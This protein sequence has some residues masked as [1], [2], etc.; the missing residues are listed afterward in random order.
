MLGGLT[1][2]PAQPASAAG[3][4]PIAAGADPFGAFAF[5]PID[6]EVD[7]PAPAAAKAELP[8]AETEGDEISA[9]PPVERVGNGIFGEFSEASVSTGAMD[10]E[11]GKPAGFEAFGDASIDPGVADDEGFVWFEAAAEEAAVEEGFG[12]F[13][14]AEEAAAVV[15]AEEAAAVVAA[16]EEEAAEEAA[17]EAAVEGEAVKGAVQ[18]AAAGLE[19]AAGGG[20]GDAGGF[21]AFE[22][23]DELEQEAIASSCFGAFETVGEQEVIAVAPASFGA[24]VAGEAAEEEEA[25]AVEEAVAEVAVEEEAVVAPNEGDFGEFSQIETV[26]AL[27]TVTAAQDGDDFGAFNQVPVVTGN[28]TGVG[29]ASGDVTGV[30][31]ASGDATG[32]RVATEDVTGVPVATVVPAVDDSVG[33]L[34]EA[35]VT[36]GNVGPTRNLDAADGGSGFGSFAEAVDEGAAGYEGDAGGFGAFEAGAYTR[37]LLRST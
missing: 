6:I 15:A 17:A 33:S 22:T 21:G 5:P 36:S 34:D 29:V 26:P 1:S 18:E 35:P 14:A 8:P 3:A 25:A 32:V 13:A 12:S 10:A 9:S 37:P 30:G 31:A 7:V 11:A 2:S 16:E 27:E 19:W 24:F 4:D 23:V 20:E 28:V